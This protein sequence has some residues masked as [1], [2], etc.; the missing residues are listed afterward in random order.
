IDVECSVPLGQRA[1]QIVL[2]CAVALSCPQRNV[3]LLIKLF[4]S[5]PSLESDEA[6]KTFLVEEIRQIASNAGTLLADEGNPDGGYLGQELSSRLM[7]RWGLACSLKFE[8]QGRNLI[9][10]ATRTASLMTRLVDHSDE[11]PIDISFE[12]TDRVC[13]ELLAIAS[14]AHLDELD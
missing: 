1:W 12:L 10:S 7:K 13:D 8:I 4:L 2:K 3:P 5:A 6:V 9:R 11:L 14:A